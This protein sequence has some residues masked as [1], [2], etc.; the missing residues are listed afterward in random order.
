VRKEMSKQVTYYKY[1]KW[2]KEPKKKDGCKYTAFD[3]P[4]DVEIEYFIK[5][6]WASEVT[7]ESAVDLMFVEIFPENTKEEQVFA[8]IGLL[9]DI[10]GT[11]LTNKEKTVVTKL[12][13]SD[14]KFDINVKSTK[15]NSSYL[16][17]LCKK[18]KDNTKTEQSNGKYPYSFMTKYFSHCNPK[19]YPIYD[20]YVDIMLRWYRD[21]NDNGFNFSDNDLNCREYE[22]FASIIDDFKDKFSL[23]SSIK[24]ID[25]FLWTAGKIFFNQYE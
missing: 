19:C 24:E 8:K 16:D 7:A 2:V 23:N 14:P 1:G 4:S 3:I 25:Q 6:E 12:F 11:N 9:N 18:V 21:H 13:A 5:T 20:S 17:S 22:L 15:R 10:Y